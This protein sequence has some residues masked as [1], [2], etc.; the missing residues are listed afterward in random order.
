MSIS[1][2]SPARIFALVPFGYTA[3]TRLKAPRDIIYLI[4][5]SWLPA[6]WFLYRSAELTPWQT[7][8]TFTVGYAAFISIYEI[9]Y[10]ANDYWDARKSH[11][12]RRR[13]PFDF[14]LTYA[15]LFVATRLLAWVLISRLTGWIA[16][17]LWLAG[18]AALAIAFAEHNLITTPGLRSA[19]FFQLAILRFAL[20]IFVSVSVEDRLELLIAAVIYYTYL[21]FLSYLESKELLRIPERR[22]PMFSVAQ[23]GMLLPLSVVISVAS[24]KSL[25]LEL[26]LYFFICFAGWAI[27]DRI[28][29]TARR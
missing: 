12:G 26:W 6:M 21:R 19:S 29:Q 8:A 17:P 13:V 15:G 27:F 24:G 1:D 10:L 4:I 18:F 3:V 9:G 11:Q 14:G 20:P 16:D 25:V 22:Q 23:I 5:S 2:S 28:P 7:I